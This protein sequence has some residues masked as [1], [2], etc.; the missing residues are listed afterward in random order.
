[1]NWQSPFSNHDDPTNNF[2][3]ESPLGVI[4]IPSFEADE[5]QNPPATKAELDECISA[6]RCRG[7][8]EVLH[9][10]FCCQIFFHVWIFRKSIRMRIGLP[11]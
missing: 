2:S 6:K 11:I 3:R 7:V 8:L 1:M 5:N 4:V 10:N 9:F